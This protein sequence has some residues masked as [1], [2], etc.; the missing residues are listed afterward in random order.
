[1]K[2]LRQI[3]NFA[4]FLV[5]FSVGALA[6]ITNH[7]VISEVYGG[8]GNSGS[9]Y[10]NDYVELYNP[11]SSPIT[12]TN[13]SVQYA[14]AAGVFQAGALYKTIFSGTIPAHG[15][16]LVKEAAGAGGTTDLP[17][18]DATGSIAMSSSNGKVALANDTISVTGPSSTNIVDFIGYG[19]TASLYEGSGPTSSLSN[20]TCAE[21]KAQSSSTAITMAAGGS[22]VTNGNGWDSNDNSAD[23]VIQSTQV[24]QNSASSAEDPPSGNQSPSISAITRGTFVPATSSTN[25]ISANVIDDGTITSVKLAISV[26]GGNYDSSVTMTFVSGST[27]SGDIPVSKHVTNGDLVKYFITAI[28]NLG[29]YSA[30]SVYGYFVGDS[31]ISS[32]KSYGVSSVAGYGARINGTLNVDANTLSSNSTYIQ[33][34]TG[35]LYLSLTGMPSSLK[36]GRNAKVEGTIGSASSHVYQ[37][38]TPNFNFVDTALGTSTITPVTLTLPLPKDSSYSNEGKLVKILGLTTDSV[39]T[40]AEHGYNFKESDNDTITV[41]IQSNGTANTVLGKTIPSIATDVTGIL[42]YYYTYMEIKPR[43]AEDLGLSTGD[44]SGTATIK[45]TS[46]LVSL[47]AVAE[48]LTVTGDGVNTLE[49]VSIQIPLTWAWTNTASYV[50][51]GAFAGKT[52]TITGDGSTTPYVITIAG[53]LLTDVNPGTIEIKDLNTPASSGN[54]SFIVKTA[55]ASGTLTPIASSPTVNITTNTFEA[56][57]TGNWNSGATWSGGIVPTST[58]DVTMTTGNVVVTITADAQCNKLTMVGVDTVG[59]VAGPVLQFNSSGALTLTVNG[60]LDLSGTPGRPKLTSNGNT[61]ATLVLKA[62]AF[63][64]ASN[65]TANGDRGLNMNEGTVKFTG[66]STDSLKTDAGFRLANFVIGD[67]TNAKILYWNQTANATMNIRSLTVKTGSS[68]IIGMESEANINPI[69]NFSTPGLPMLTGGIVIET[70]ASFLVNNAL[71]GSNTAYINLKDGGITNNGTLNL[72]SP[73]GSRKY[74]VAFGELTEDPTGSKQTIGGSSAGTYS[75]VKVGAIDTVILNNSMNVDTMLVNGEIV[76]SSGKTVIGVV[77]TKR[78]LTQAVANTCGGIGVTVNALDA[79]PDTTVI[80]RITGT[81]QTGGGNESILRA[82]SFSPKVNIGLNAT[83]SF[84]YDQSELNGQNE[85]T[86]SFWKSTDNGT[87]WWAQS[88]TFDAGLNKIEATGLSSLDFYTASDA[89]HSIGATTKSHTVTAGWNLI[90]L[91]YYV[92][93]ARKSILY[94]TAPGNA[95]YY[96]GTYKVEDTLKKG[97]GYWLKFPVDATFN[98]SGAD[99]LNDTIIVVDGWNMIGSIGKNIL[100]ASIQQIPTDIVTSKYF[101]FTNTYLI[102]DTIK[103]SHGYWVKIN[104]GGKLVLNSGVLVG[105]NNSSSSENG[106]ALNTLTITDQTGKKQ[107]LYFGNGIDEKQLQSHDVPPLGPEEIFDIRFASNR[108]IEAVDRVQESSKEFSINLQ[109]VQYPITIEWDIKQDIGNCYLRTESKN[110]LI[111]GANSIIFNEP[112]TSLR[113]GYNSQKELPKNFTLGKSYPN[114]FNP[115]TKFQIEIPYTTVVNIVVY[116]AIGRKIKT[117]YHGEKEAGISVLE[118]NGLSDD[119]RPAT[120]GIYFIKMAADKFNAITKAVLLK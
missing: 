36:A 64:N 71:S 49:S 117:L 23:F 66:A 47:T 85:A 80:Y 83:M 73:N 81:P 114:P 3:F 79:T 87:T 18:A 9:T 19:S 20:T 29:A 21:R 113:L 105:S 27:Y 42:A 8:G 75:F 110:Q 76:E 120:S 102:S 67:G 62:G 112:V 107:T 118:W 1:M 40:F 68:F 89:A 53:L 63:T 55:L 58:D 96:E 61:D 119:N 52:P 16:F 84:Y 54:T 33:D 11:T 101:E 15:F 72:K 37:L 106:L 7:V 48:T 88:A 109:G 98:F 35:G 95:F 17:L 26:N 22:D 78:V 43:K 108:N 100:T 69:G 59:G 46:R 74:S 82:F 44:G 116:D 57:A 38:Q 103:P 51:T 14:S 28:D 65:T 4:L 50:L 93:D 70:G 34:A 24:P 77:R 91:P 31:P 39:G 6:Q 25:T 94:P 13:W 115:S 97:F 99:I 32:I 86:L 12:M 111:T 41:Y 45:P 30:S 92:A 90:S 56:I 2:T 10:K 5:L 104:G 60:K